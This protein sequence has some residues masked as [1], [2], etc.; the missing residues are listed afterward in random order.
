MRDYIVDETRFVI[1]D[2]DKTSYFPNPYKLPCGIT[3][4]EKEDETDKWQLYISDDGKFYILA[5][6]EELFRKWTMSHLLS[7]DDFDWV[8][9]KGKDLYLLFSPCNLKISRLTN[10]RANNSLRTAHSLLSAFS[11]LRQLD[12]ESN[13][14]DGIYIESHSIILPTYSLVGA[15]SDR[16]LF[17]NAMRGP[18]D[19]ENLKAPDGLND[20]VSYAYFNNYLKKHALKSN[21]VPPVFENGEA[22]DD[23]MLGYQN[24]ALVTSPLIIRD[25]FQLFDTTSDRYLLLMNKLWAKALMEASL[26]SQITL[27]HVVISSKNYYVISLK[28]DKMVECMD[29]RHTG[30]T[31]ESAMELAQA[32]RRTRQ[33]LPKAYLLDALYVQELG[34]LLPSVFT[35]SDVTNDRDLMADCLVNGPFAMAPFMDDINKDLLTIATNI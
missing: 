7:D 19:P 15:V 3:I 14:R 1:S 23:F 35:S 20:T 16:A 34:M 28:K 21:S 11:H 8:E 12:L 25:H 24:K 18:N 30:L 26:L 6:V 29:D 9:V 33:L 13:L 10:V 32:I 22:I 31:K 2:D 5:V 17:E 4:S 27:N